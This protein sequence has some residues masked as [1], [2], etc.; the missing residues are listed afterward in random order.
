MKKLKA[1]K[2]VY[3]YYYPEVRKIVDD[4]T[5]EYP[6]KVFLTSTDPGFPLDT[7]EQ[8]IIDKYIKLQRNNLP[9][10]KDYKYRYYTNGSSEAIFH[11]LSKI[12]TED[13]NTPI[14]CIEGDYEGYKE[15]A[16]V[17]NMKLREI[18]VTEKFAQSYSYLKP[19][20]FFISN[21]SAIHGNYLAK[22]FIKLLTDQGHKIVY[23]ATYVGM[24]PPK[25][26]DISDENIIAVLISFSKPYGLFYYRT[27]FTFTR[28]PVPSLYANKW[29]KNILSLMIVDKI[30]DVYSAPN[31]F[32]FRYYKYQ[33][34]FIDEISKEVEW[35]IKPSDVFLPAHA[36][37]PEVDIPCLEKFSR[38]RY[39]RLCLTPYFLDNESN[40]EEYKHE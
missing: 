40:L 11:L 10:L 28:V 12:K 20:V 33:Q 34:Q 14:Y 36:R 4:I 1:I 2:S 22:E 3:S 25:K 23:D 38:N 13:P 27:G 37:R 30:M 8:P 29:F 18:K 35:Q 17:L 16:K 9:A 5:K 26:L 6:H 7:F 31:Y 39:Y 15:Y 21:P 32:Y 24:T 19:G